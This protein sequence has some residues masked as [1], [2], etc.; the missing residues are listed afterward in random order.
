VLE[1]APAGTS[2]H[3]VADEGDA[4]RDI[5]NVIGRRLN[6][7]ITTTSAENFGP[8]GGIFAQDQPASS[9]HTRAVLGWQ[10]THPSL[11]TDLENLQP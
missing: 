1:M 10:P 8:L 11:L 4:V 2:W 5:A 9:A 6:L 7:P 3:A